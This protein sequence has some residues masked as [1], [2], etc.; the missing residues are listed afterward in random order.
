MIVSRKSAEGFLGK[1]LE[2]LGA[3]KRSYYVLSSDG[4]K[5]LGGPHTKESAKQRL[6]QVEYFKRNP[7]TFDCRK[8]APALLVLEEPDGLPLWHHVRTVTDM[9]S[10]LRGGFKL[11]RNPKIL[12]GVYTV[13][14]GWEKPDRKLHEHV[15][16]IRLRKGAV[17]LDTD[18]ER[19]MHA[20]AG[21]GHKSWNALWVHVLKGMGHPFDL[22]KK[23]NDQDWAAKNEDKLNAL[24]MGD[25]RW[26]RRQRYAK[27]MAAELKR[28]KVDALIQ[29]GEF[30]ILNLK[31]I[32][33]VTEYTK[34]N[35]R[36]RNPRKP[37]RGHLNVKPSD[38]SYF[39]LYV[40][41]GK[42]PRDILSLMRDTFSAGPAAGKS[43]V[44]DELFWWLSEVWHTL[45]ANRSVSPAFIDIGIDEMPPAAHKVK[46][47]LIRLANESKNRW[48]SQPARIQR[49]GAI[50]PK[51]WDAH[52]VEGD[53]GWR[54]PVTPIFDVFGVDI[55]DEIERD[56]EL[57]DI[58]NSQ[59]RDPVGAAAVASD[60]LQQ[61]G[62]KPE[63][64]GRLKLKELHRRAARRNPR[65][66]NSGLPL[67]TQRSLP[68]ERRKPQ[69]HTNIDPADILYFREFVR[70]SDLPRK[71]RQGMEQYMPPPWHKGERGGW[72]VS[73]HSIDQLVSQVNTP[74]ELSAAAIELVSRSKERWLDRTPRQRARGWDLEGL[75]RDWH[76]WTN[77][78]T[79]LW[80]TFGAAGLAAIINEPELRAILSAHPETPMASAA[81]ASDWMQQHGVEVI[82]RR[83][84]RRLG[85]QADRIENPG[86][87]I[88]IG[89]AV[90]F[91][92]YGEPALPKGVAR[93]RRERRDK[94]GFIHEGI[95]ARMLTAEERKKIARLE[96]N[97]RPFLKREHDWNEVLISRPGK[98]LT[99]KQI[100]DYYRGVEKKIWPYLEGQTVMVIFAPKKNEFIL[101]RKRDGDDKYIK[102]TKR[103]G[104]DDQNSLEY[105]VNRRA[106]EFHVV[107]TTKTAPILWLDLDMHKTRDKA[108]RAGLLRKMKKA[109]R[110]IKKVFR[111]MGV[112]RT[113]VY[114]SGQDGGLHFEG[115][116]PKR[117]NVDALRRAL[118]KALDKEFEGDE[119]FTTGRAKSGQIRLDT[120]TF[121]HLG[122][123][124]A[125]YS[126]TIRGT[127]KRRITT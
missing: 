52:E 94:G 63:P 7:E 122:S 16:E 113:F 123:L 95:P 61:R 30:I 75:R 92:H 80:E 65:R 93:R 8:L 28:C 17:I 109:A 110:R 12:A 86:D 46:A 40:P 60:W 48:L 104:I 49:M 45:D 15:L 114:E 99:R 1:K 115:D 3:G 84:A 51:N 102:L 105:W 29:G 6:R 72:Q 119:V 125:P 14:F 26:E 35:P 91:E 55:L 2:G 4:T 67:G 103:R 47:A 39:R 127:P 82:D 81:V 79:P 57:R 83:A 43:E 62:F 78:V 53:K 38:V 44:T 66:R 98:K 58:L 116:L 100:R 71:M 59:P 33:S 42:L 121:H 69:G 117:R 19:P 24:L 11:G 97:P 101:R 96:G 21:L 37:S 126:M 124:R 111:E 9:R 27:A 118:T 18:S 25:G 90:G 74:Q 87:V 106:I 73:P 54:N 34:R 85:R 41:L 22:A 68:K 5:N 107:L 36:K 120:T 88:P 31:S 23:H 89:R 10:I 32:A 56:S 108:A 20:V 50:Q 77:P 70:P 64:A 112:N 13:P 76:N